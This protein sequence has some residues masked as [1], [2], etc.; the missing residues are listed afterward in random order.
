M[1]EL[2]EKQ[3]CAEM[4]LHILL[5]DS[6]ASSGRTLR[7]LLRD[8]GYEVEWIRDGSSAIV[9]LTRGHLPRAIIVSEPLQNVAG[10][11]VLKYARAVSRDIEGCLVTAYPE[12]SAQ[13]LQGESGFTVLAKPLA[14]A[15]LLAHLPLRSHACSA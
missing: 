7:R 2:A 15:E 5:I 8:D 9:R 3:D 14:Y 12:L 13:R 11:A 4:R 6:D 1:S 10:D